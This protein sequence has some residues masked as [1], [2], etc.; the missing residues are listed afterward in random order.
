MRKRLLSAV[1]SLVLILSL[2]PTVAYAASDEAVSSANALYQ[3]GLFKGTGKDAQGNPIFDLDR[4]PTRYEAVT[5]LVRLLG[6]ANEAESK[7]WNTPF[8]DL[9]ADWAKPYVGYA[10]ANK[11]TSGTSSGIT[12]GGN[13]DTTLSQ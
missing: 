8:T 11:L 5:L 4:T 7:E 2:V 6:R 9:T 10:Y 12:Y 3:L 13:E 1:V